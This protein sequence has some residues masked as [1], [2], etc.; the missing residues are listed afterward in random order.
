MSV[1]H[2][3]GSRA[4]AGR[5]GFV[6]PSA[7]ILYAAEDLAALTLEA[8]EVDSADV[9]ARSLSGMLLPY[10]VVG[11][12]SIGPVTVPGP[13]IVQ[14]PA[15]LSRV[16]LTDGHGGDE[17]PMVRSIGYLDQ[18]RDTDTGLRG[19]FHV[20]RTPSGDVALLE[21][22]ERVRDGFSV[23]LTDLHVN[24]RGEVTRA[25]LKRVALV[26]TPAWADAREDGLAASHHHQ[27]GTRM[28]Q[29]QR[30]RLAALRAQDTL[31]QDEAAELARLAALEADEDDDQDGQDGDDDQD[32]QDGDQDG[33]DDGQDLQAS[34]RQRRRRAA[35]VPGVPGGRRRSRHTIQ[36]LA[37]AQARIFRGE[38]RASL[39][40]ALS[41]VTS[42]ANIWTARDDY[43]GELWSGLEY[44]RRYVSL[45]QGGPLPS[46]KGTGWRWVVKPA[47]GDYAG[48]KA[49]VPS[50]QPTTEATEWAA[51]RLAGAHDLDRKFF[52][53]GDTEFIASY[54][55]A[56]TEDYA[57]KSDDKARLFVLAMA[58]VATAPVATAGA[59][60]YHAAAQ[61]AQS[62]F[63][64]TGGRTPD[65]L[66]V[67][68]TDT[69][70]LLNTTANDAPDPRILEM[71]GVTP[72]KFMQ[73]PGVPAGRVVAGIRQA[74]RF[75][76]L[77]TS[78]IRVEA[79]NI[80]NGG[81]DGG[82]FGY[83]A[84]EET[85][86]GGVAQARFGA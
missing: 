35:R 27:E 11:H 79:L 12:T 25:R 3:V 15:E 36:D 42:T 33:A 9:E 17:D 34:H 73:V 13:G 8:S 10:G 41:D 37:A 39:E 54:Y 58:D 72:D 45:L 85:F 70:N 28:T 44:T 23:E 14:V 68:S 63:D 43:A 56:L 40:A 20:G 6:V 2:N 51:A 48:D 80:A 31:T 26:I 47:V 49:A 62:V 64:N 7:Q 5:G 21:A 86:A 59:T 66:L 22:S 76:E 61:A 82:V 55:R 18:V 57:M 71:F 38:S 19:G 67:N 29:E 30:E 77:S 84:T 53:F 16:K 52:D 1:S 50:N 65:Y 24:D 4:P 74:G 46:Y 75:R 81:V 83:Y 60:I 32:G 69:F 78:P